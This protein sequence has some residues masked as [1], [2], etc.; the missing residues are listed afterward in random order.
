MVRI[1][2]I[3]DQLIIYDLGIGHYICYQRI[4]AFRSTFPFVQLTFS[5]Q[6]L[7]SVS[8]FHTPAV[9]FSIPET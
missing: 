8:K 5:Q 7:L 4:P 9:Q 1:H 6:L 3:N 2:G